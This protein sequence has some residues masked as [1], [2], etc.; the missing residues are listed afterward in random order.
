MR[1]RFVR[2]VFFLLIGVGIGA[3]IGY[4][5]AQREMKSGVIKASPD[6]ALKRKP[7]RKKP[8]DFTTMAKDFGGEFTLVNQDGK[9]VTKDNFSDSYKLIFFGFAYCPEVCPT[10]LMKM[11]LIL[12]DLKEDIS[13]KITPMFI[14]IDPERD[15][16]EH[17]KQ[18]VQQFN[19]D[20]VG[21]TGT[22]EQ[23]EAVKNSFRVY[24]SKVENED[25]E[26]YMMDH[27]SFMY[28]MDKD[29]KLVA[30]YSATDTAEDIADD[31]YAR[32]L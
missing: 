31:I 3:T 32:G 4:F 2:W 18:Y 7:S 15:T 14:S 19:P 28:L 20:M 23:I 8:K 30:M 29:N 10:E 11:T 27:S 5:D 12:G 25:M 6:D 21:L 24:A 22:K 13:T 17:L 1:N 16:P 26:G 9:T